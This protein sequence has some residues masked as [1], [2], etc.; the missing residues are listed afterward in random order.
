MTKYEAAKMLVEMATD[1]SRVG[2]YGEEKY[3][4]AVA[5]ACA[6]LLNGGEAEGKDDG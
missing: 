5:L 3:N 1:L 2:C 6:A 4:E